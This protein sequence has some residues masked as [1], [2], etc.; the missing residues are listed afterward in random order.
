MKKILSLAALVLAFFTASAY[1]ITFRVDMTN[2]T[3]SGSGV[4]IAGNFA[5]PD[6]TGPAENPAYVN[7]DPSV[8]Q[9]LDGNAENIY[10]VTL[11]LVAGFEYQFKYINGNDW[12]FAENVPGECNVGGNRAYNLGTS[13]VVLPVICYG[14]C[15]FCASNPQFHDVTFVVDMQS[16]SVSPNG[17]HLAGSFD[18]TPAPHTLAAWDPAAIEMLDPDMDQVY[19]V[20]L[21]LAEGYYYEYKFVN[22]NNWG[23]DEAVPG[24][25]ASEGGNRFYSVGTSNSTT[26][27]VCFASCADC[28]PSAGN[29]DVTFQVNMN[30]QTVSPNGVHLAGN[31]GSDGYVDWDPAG[32]AMDDSDMD[33]IYTLTLTL[34][35]G[36]YYEYKF[37]NGNDWPFAEIPSGCVNGSGNR[38]F[39]L[40]ASDLTLEAIC[41][42]E[43]AACSV[44]YDVT[45]RVNMNFQSVSPNGVHVAGSFDNG[46]PTWQAGGIALSDPSTNGIYEVTLTLN[47]GTTYEYKFINDND[48]P[49]AETV[50]SG[51]GVDDGFGNL[52]R[53]I[54]VTSDITLD[55]VCF[56]ACADC[57][58][59][60]T[61]NTA[62]NYNAS[63]NVDDGSCLFATNYYVDQ[64]LDGYGSGAAV[65]LC[66]DPGL[67][68]SLLDN[69]CDDLNSNIHPGATEVCGNSTDDDCDG[70]VKR[71][72]FGFSYC[73]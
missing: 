31:F 41:Y 6:Y 38:F 54:T 23:F 24:G 17:V 66:T 60:C 19:E 39:T 27:E 2:Q 32:L 50:P 73:K 59:G 4:H 22:G 11:D 69:D 64:D 8:I 1:Q 45:F 26:T 30:N 51:C 55:I 40:G 42:G 34:T 5:D 48:W 37:V 9:L 15:S 63:A 36:I 10:E 67:G 7:W 35:E 52:N 72:M 58:E 18:Y 68:Y 57:F 71:G 43:C 56:G 61:N 12:P 3:V 20:T 14:E 49:G 62:C 33:G 21:T 29:F 28:I 16:V 25:C 44:Q 70:L 13:D 46:Y 47:E 53:S 65:S